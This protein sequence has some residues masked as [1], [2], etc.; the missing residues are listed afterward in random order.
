VLNDYK[1]LTGMK[2]CLEFESKFFNKTDQTKMDIVSDS[3]RSMQGILKPL[4]IAD[5]EVVYYPLS[6]NKGG[7]IFGYDWDENDQF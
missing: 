5:N 2:E 1:A 3:I 6:R 4:V 7:I